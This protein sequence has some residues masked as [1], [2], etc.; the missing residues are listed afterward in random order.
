MNIP[1]LT[2]ALKEWAV[3]CELLSRGDCALLLRKGGIH[4]DLGPGRFR[5]DHDRFALFPAAEH[6]RLDWIK[7]AFRLRDEPLPARPEH[8]A[9]PGYAEVAKVWEIPGREAFDAL[10]DLHPWEP[11]Q[12]DMRFDYKPDRPLYL[13]ALRVYRLPRPH[14]VPYTEAY[15]G[16]RSWVDLDDGDA[17]PI[18]AATPAMSEDAMGDVIERVDRAMG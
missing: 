13:V 17:V 18:E 12:I 14:R 5:L 10:D 16:C 15:L 3:V 11:P 4:E 8:V 9:I 1:A 7:P 2:V 6:E